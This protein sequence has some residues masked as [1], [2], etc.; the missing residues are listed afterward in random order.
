M[1]KHSKRFTADLEK[2]DQSKSYGVAEALKILQDFS[3]PKFDPS[4]ELSIRLGI[5]PKRSDQIVRGAVSLPK[6]IGKSKKVIVFADGEEGDK[7][8]A[9]GAVEVGMEELA[10]KIQKGWMD[11]DVAI[12]IPRAMKVVGKLG[13]VLGPQ[14][15]M[16]SPKSGT[17]TDKIEAAVKEFIAGKIEFRNDAAGNIQASVGKV[18]FPAEDLQENVEA[19]IEHIRS[20]K[21]QTVKGHYMVSAF[22]SSSM[23]PS[24]QLSVN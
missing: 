6:G 22:I 16:P 21:P 14:G 18:S 24:V 20:L 19:F 12:A 11:F 2:I 7:A 5:D 1:K 15:K 10:E 23:S 13:K 17:V 3:R 8:K 4:V 9:L